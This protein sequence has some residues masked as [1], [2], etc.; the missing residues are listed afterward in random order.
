M[1]AFQ[2]WLKF[3][4]EKLLLA[5]VW[6]SGIKCFQEVGNCSL[7]PVPNKGHLSL[8]ANWHWINLLGVVSYIFFAKISIK[9]YR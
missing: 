6:D 5:S 1:V 4:L 3:D 2:K 9:T 8:C 7:V